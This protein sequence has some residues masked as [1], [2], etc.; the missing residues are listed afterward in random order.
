VFF[1]MN[2]MQLLSRPEVAE[3]LMKYFSSRTLYQH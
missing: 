2:H 1:N 3:L